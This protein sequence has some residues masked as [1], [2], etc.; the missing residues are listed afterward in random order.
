MSINRK[1]GFC[2]FFGSTRDV[3]IFTRSFDEI[4]G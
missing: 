2:G 1:H 3:M 4:S